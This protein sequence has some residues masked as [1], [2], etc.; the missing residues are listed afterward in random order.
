MRV[1][2]KG[3]MFF[4][5]LVNKCINFWNLLLVSGLVENWVCLYCDKKLIVVGDVVRIF[6]LVNRFKYFLSFIFFG[7]C[8]M[9]IVFGLSV[10]GRVC[11]FGFGGVRVSVLVLIRFGSLDIM[12]EYCRF[13]GKFVDIGDDYL[14]CLMFFYMVCC[15]F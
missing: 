8:N 15:C 12:V 13:G 6:I 9:V 4:K 7:F 10:G 11:E 5:I 14:G 3:C 1:G 2:L